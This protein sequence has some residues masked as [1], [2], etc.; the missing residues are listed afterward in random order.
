M[1]TTM[2]LKNEE[3]V[4][5]IIKQM[6]DQSYE[7]IKGEEVLLCMDCCDVDLY[8]AA[9]SFPDLEDAIKQNFELDEHDEII[10]R[11]GYIQLMNELDEYYVKL[12]FDS[13]YYDYFPAGYY[14]VDGEEEESETDMLAPKGIY[15]A[16]FEEALKK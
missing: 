9:D 8:V 1:K 2:K 12:H 10:D 16:P 6:V 3:K 5:K 13:G 7:Q 15:Y 11:D 14:I 4:K